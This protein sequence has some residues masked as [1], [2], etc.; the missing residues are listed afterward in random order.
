MGG[1]KAQK[2]MFDIDNFLNS[3]P[4]APKNKKGISVLREASPTK[5]NQKARI[6][7]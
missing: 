7:P 5:M 3:Q 6:M 1:M 2:K 4:I